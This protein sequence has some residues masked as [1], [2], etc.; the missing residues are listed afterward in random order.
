[1]ARYRNAQMWE[2][3]IEYLVKESVLWTSEKTLI[4]YGVH[5]VG[6][7]SGWKLSPYCP[8]S[9]LLLPVPDSHSVYFSL[10]FSYILPPLSLCHLFL[11]FF[12]FLVHLFWDGNYGS[13]STLQVYC[14]TEDIL[15]LLSF[16]CN[17]PATLW[18]HFVYFFINLCSLIW[19]I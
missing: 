18:R 17:T 3:L 16:Y 15:D 4:S 1:M 13:Q 7:L 5:P 12:I 10:P 6:I 2:D 19:R 9:L 8:I 11:S 14:V